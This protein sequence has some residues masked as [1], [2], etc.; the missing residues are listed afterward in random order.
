[1]RLAGIP[2]NKKIGECLLALPLPQFWLQKQFFFLGGGN[3]FKS[4]LLS[5]TKIEKRTKQNFFLN[6]HTFF[7]KKTE[8]RF[9]DN[10][11]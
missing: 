8:K 1:M 3:G 10:N 11:T 5:H 6:T 9:C 4:S 2:I 7:V